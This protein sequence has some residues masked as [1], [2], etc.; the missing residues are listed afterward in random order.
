MRPRA[1]VESLMDL[2]G[3]IKKICLTPQSEWS[4][5]A[6]E[7]TPAASLITQYVLP[8]AGGRRRCRIHRRFADRPDAAVHR[9]HLS[10]TVRHRPRSGGVQRR[11]GGHRRRPDFA[12]HRRAR[13]DVRGAEEQRAGIQGGGV[14]VYAR[15]GCRRVAD[16]AGAGDPR[17][18]RRAVRPLSAVSRT[19]SIDE[20]SS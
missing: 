8:L 16:P 5:I 15:L 12:D 19:S 3:R 1:A 4:V 18:A 20:V 11:H 7:S 13:A 10:R 9:R 6:E 2:I 14:L 17:G